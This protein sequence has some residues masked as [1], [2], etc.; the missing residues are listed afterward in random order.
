MGLPCL[1]VVGFRTCDSVAGRIGAGHG[2][3][4]GG[5]G[6]YASRREVHVAQIG[7]LLHQKVESALSEVPSQVLDIIGAELVHDDSHHQARTRPISP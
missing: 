2:Y 3:C 7:T 4:G 1:A 5:H 6:I